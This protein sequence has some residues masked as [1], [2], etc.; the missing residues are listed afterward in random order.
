M[1]SRGY[2]PLN[3]VQLRTVPGDPVTFA[4]L[5]AE[6]RQASASSLRALA[7]SRST[8]ISSGLSILLDDQQMPDMTMNTVGMR[9][10]VVTEPVGGRSDSWVRNGSLLRVPM[11]LP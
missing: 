4:Y 9:G 7:Q 2:H 11:L 8:S 5:F 3:G 6:G 1:V 10:A